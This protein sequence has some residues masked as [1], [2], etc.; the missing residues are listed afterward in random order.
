MIWIGIMFLA[1]MV[2]EWRS[3]RKSQSNR[4]DQWIVLTISVC[5]FILTEVLFAIKD[6][7]NIAILFHL[8]GRSIG[9]L[10]FGGS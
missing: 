1:I 7:W 8:V 2:F 5:L 3:Q 10:M 9:T 4:R 6:K